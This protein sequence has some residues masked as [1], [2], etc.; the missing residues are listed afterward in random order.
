MYADT[1]FT[2]YFNYLK[3]IS[4]TIVLFSFAVVEV[5]L[6]TEFINLV[7]SVKSTLDKEG[8]HF[9]RGHINTRAHSVPHC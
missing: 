1:D 3:L 9:R 6:D 7:V 4:L 8:I 5:L 2:N